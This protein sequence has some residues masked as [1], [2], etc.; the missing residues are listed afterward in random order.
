MSVAT[1]QGVRVIQ[2]L[3]ELKI[4]AHKPDLSQCTLNLESRIPKTPVDLIHFRTY[5]YNVL[6]DS[7]LSLGHLPKYL[8]ILVMPSVPVTNPAPRRH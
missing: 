1:N 2:S 5:R 8:R 3:I 6:L 7:A 4:A